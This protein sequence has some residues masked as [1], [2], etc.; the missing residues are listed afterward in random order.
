MSPLEPGDVENGSED[1][2]DEESGA[3]DESTGETDE[4]EES[5]EGLNPKP[6]WQP[7]Q[8]TKKEIQEHELNH[9]PYRS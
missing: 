1:V 9:I 3:R 2:Q 8:P 5:E 4:L 7:I 6:V